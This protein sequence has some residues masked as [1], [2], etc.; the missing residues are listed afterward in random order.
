[1]PGVDPESAPVTEL[2][3]S[4]LRLLQSVEAGWWRH[5]GH[6]LSLAVAQLTKEDASWSISN[7]SPVSA[8]YGFARTRNG[9]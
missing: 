1:M 6:L 9:R 8:R 4:F 7:T 2:G 5:D 3:P